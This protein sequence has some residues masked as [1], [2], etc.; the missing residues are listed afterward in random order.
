MTVS[1]FFGQDFV[2]VF[3]EAGPYI[4]NLKG[5]TVVIG[6][7]SYVV[8]EY[9]LI[10]LLQDIN[11]L[12]S[13]GMRL[14]I[15]FGVYKQIEE[16]YQPDI[17]SSINKEQ[18]QTIKELVGRV[19]IDIESYLS[20]GYGNLSVSRSEVNVLGANYISAKSKGVIGGQDS[21][22]LGEVRKINLGLMKDHLEQRNIILVNPL[23]YSVSGMS[24]YI[25]MSEMATE[26]AISLQAEKLV[27][28]TRANGIVNV[29]GEILNNLTLNEA[30]R[31]MQE[32]KQHTDIIKISHSINR[33]L[34]SNQVKRVQLI[35]GL[36]QGSLLSELFTRD[37]VG[38]SMS[39]SSFTNIR[40]A[41]STDIPTL[42]QIINPLVK[43]GYLL[44]RS[45]SYFE[46][47]IN[48]FFVIEYDE[49][50]YGCVQFRSYEGHSAELACLS[51]LESARDQGYGEKL[52]A[53]VQEE[54]KIKYKTKLFALTTQAGDWF[55]ERGFVEVSSKELPEVR[56]LEY[57]SSKR[58]SKIFLKTL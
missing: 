7:N 37:G 14:V 18:M 15:V 30:Q 13:L 31:V 17:G 23:G 6:I 1:E 54:A 45:R 5:K 34:S 35:S 4:N 49:V 8:E 44:P 26:I 41:N 2:K 56:W 40:S 55:K 11:L 10:S 48:E 50:I 16:E 42:L 21:E 25:P 53:R 39:Y 24:Y 9:Y 58:Q 57:H 51:V 38:T 27:F 36:E 19:R 46:A 29:Q 43:R 32:T 12:N 20:I 52:L 33:A 22:H 47:H 3:R 28:I